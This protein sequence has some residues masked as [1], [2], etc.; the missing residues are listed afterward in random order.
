[1]ASYSVLEKSWPDRFVPSLRKISVHYNG[2]F[3]GKINRQI[4][5]KCDRKIMTKTDTNKSIKKSFFAETEEAI[6]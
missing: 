3:V 4:K 1:M 2:T 5:N 6:L